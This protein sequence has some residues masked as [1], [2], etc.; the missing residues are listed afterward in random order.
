MASALLVALGATGTAAVA[1]PDPNSRTLVAA[2]APVS[3]APVSTAPIS[4]ARVAVRASVNPAI[5]GERVTYRA[6]LGT[7][8][9]RPVTL[10]VQRSG[11]WRD[12]LSGRS[13][14][15]GAVALTPRPA[16]TAGESTYRII[17]PATRANGTALRA[18]TTADIKQRV[19]GQSVRVTLASGVAV[20]E[21]GA[22]TVQATPARPGREVTLREQRPSAGGGVSWAV[23]ATSQQDRSGRA[24]FT[25]KRPAAQQLRGY[26]SAS[27]GAPL[28]A[29]AAV[30]WPLP[31]ALARV[32][33]ARTP[34]ATV[35]DWVNWASP[36]DVFYTT[37]RSG[38]LVVVAR[39]PKGDALRID[40][41]D[42]RTYA[43]VG[44]SRS[45]SLSGWSEWG[46]FYAGPDG[47]FYVLVGQLNE[48]Q[49][50]AIDVAAVRRYDPQWSLVGTATIK[51]GATQLFKGLWEP[52]GASAAHMALVGDRLVVHMGRGM[53]RTND[54][55]RHQSNFTFE[56][57]VPT[58]AATTFDDAAGSIWKSPYVSHS[59]QT[60]VTTFESSLVLLD[61]G[62]AYPRALRMHVFKGYPS[63]RDFTAFDV[64]SF[65]GAAG[66]NATG[67][68]ITG[69][70]SGPQ[71]VLVVGNTVRHD[72]APRGTFHRDER[73]NAFLL[74]VNP[75]TQNQRMQPLTQF[76]PA[77]AD[78]VG[79]PRI[80]AVA[81]DRW[82]VIFNVERSGAHRTEY[83]LVDSAG[84][85]HAS[86]SFA[87]LYFPAGSEPLRLGSK[88]VW[89]GGDP[90][91]DTGEA[92]LF[93][94]DITDPARPSIR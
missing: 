3:T 46:G 91:S 93:G 35:Y 24:L 14:A 7:K 42:P 29:S 69:L 11:G 22:V 72:D 62:D 68:A 45:I 41:F 84:Q 79:H 65:N 23:V 55:L 89:V 74:W 5:V 8:G 1:A 85:V 34:D 4:T 71:G 17:A 32:D 82:A 40:T 87:A 77:G 33:V 57:H 76:S 18:L 67:T 56:V 12:V 94:I 58:M 27:G 9:V 28:V 30:S 19:V 21:S 44:A 2:A 80:A 90:K 36:D 86:A 61:H 25:V 60:L 13:T 66:D 75:H 6:S 83:R 48:A 38:N 31:G 81:Q 47:H 51:G 64:M 10:Q 63:S 73:R 39:T 43:K 70:V 78:I 26:V 59:F 20:G 50:D 37:D 49:N 88:I 52:F 92:H 15:S 53:Y 54:G 16:T